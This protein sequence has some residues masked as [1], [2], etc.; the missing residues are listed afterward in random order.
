LVHAG[1]RI[2]GNELVFKDPGA[3]RDKKMH[4][5]MHVQIL[6]STGRAGAP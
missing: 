5:P 2:W 1:L 6:D 3:N 4:V